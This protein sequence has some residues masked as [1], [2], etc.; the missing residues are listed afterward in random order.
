MTEYRKDLAASIRARLLNISRA[1]G[2]SFDEL[3]TLYMLERLLFR[4]SK[5]RYRDNFIL[6]GGLLLC[7]LFDDPHRTT[8]DI[9]FLAKQIP[10]QMDYIIQ[11]FKEIC[12][13]EE[14]DGLIFHT[15]NIDIKRIKEDADYEGV[16]VLLDC[17]L[18]QAKKI[19][20]IDIGYGDV[21]VPKPQ[22]LKYPVI[23]EMSNPNILVYSLE[24]VV[25]EKF[26]AMI[27]LAQMNSRMKDFY[28][29]YTL[30]EYF[31]FDG[32][33]LYEA[34]FETFQRR[35]TPYERNAIVFS[36]DF[37]LSSDKQKQWTAFMKRTV[38]A[39]VE[40]VQIMDRIREFL[41]PVYMALLNEREFF[42]H[43]SVDTKSWN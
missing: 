34:I 20:Q 40:F 43:W 8:K 6:K 41:F 31:D 14:R 29:I 42:G 1:Q 32:R 9:D 13:V 19:L 22:I 2:K 15:D 27:K 10:S 4:V 18:G 35:G 30:S 21:V 7:V 23:L 16:R 26:E 38:K 28:D 12:A 33:S 24:S 5:S 3:L 39:Q 37:G 11:L 36:K 25:A 17:R